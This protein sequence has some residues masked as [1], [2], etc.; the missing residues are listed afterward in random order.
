M[1]TRT[2]KIFTTGRSQ[3]VRLPAEFRFEESEVFVRRDP[4]T[5]DVILSRKPESWDGLFELYGKDQVPDDF[6]GPDDRQQPSHDRDPF[7]GWKE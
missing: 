1:A 2:A 4:K 7:E 6:L 3:A 5:G